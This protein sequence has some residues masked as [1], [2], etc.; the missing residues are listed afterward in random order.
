MTKRFYFFMLLVLSWLSAEA[1]NEP[2]AA[3]SNN[4]KTLTFYYDEYKTSRGGMDLGPFNK[5][6]DRGWN[7]QSLT[8]TTVVFDESFSDYT[9]LTSTAFWFCE[10]S[11]LTAITGIEHLNTANVTNMDHMFSGCEAL[12]SLDVTHFNTAKVTNMRLMFYGCSGLTSLDVS[13]FN[14]SNVTTMFGMFSGC[15]GLTSLDVSN[16]NTSNV[17]WMTA[18]FSSC[19]SLTS[20]DVT[21][22]NTD[23]V[24]EMSG[25]FSGCSGLKSLDVSNFNTANVQHMESMFRECLSLTTI[26]CNDAWN[27]K[28]SE[29]MFSKCTSLVGAIA[30]DESKTDVT[31]ANPETGYFTKLVVLPYA[32]LSEDNTTLTFYYDGYKKSRGG[33]SVGP[34]SNYA[35]PGWSGKRDVITKV[36]FDESFANCKTLTSTAR[37][38]YS[39]S[40][41]KTITGMEYLNTD[42]VTSMYEMFYGCKTLTSLDV[43]HFNTD[44]VTNMGF[45]FYGCSG[46]TSLDVS[47]FNTSNVMAFTAMFAYC[48]ALTSLDVS[49]FNT[50]NV[51]SMFSMFA[52]CNSLTSLDVSNFNTDKV[53]DMSYMFVVCP[54]LTVLD[55]SNFNTDNVTDMSYMFGGCSGLT[56][57]YCNDTWNCE[58]SKSMFYGCT[59]LVGAI[60][61]DESKNDVAYANTK[62]GY[63]SFIPYA[64]LS[65]DNK[66]LT[67]YCDEYKKSRGG[68]GVGP[69]S[70]YNE[71]GWDAQRANITKVVFDESF[72]NC[73]TLTSTAY[74]FYF[75][76][77]LKTITGIEHLNTDNVTKMNNMFRG[78]SNLTNLDV[79]HFNTANVENMASMFQKCSSLTS[80]DL[81]DFNTD[82]VTNMGAMFYG[83]S[84]LKTIYCNDTWS[85]GFSTLMFTD[86][87]SLVGAIAYDSDKKNV[88]YANPET[89]YFTK[90]DISPYA[91]LNDDNTT[92]TFYY[93]KYKIR[94][95][96]MDVGPFSEYG[97]AEWYNK[98]D[99]ITKVVFDE[100]FAKCKT[101]TSTAY[102]FCNCRELTTITGIEHLNTGNV[103]NMLYMF[104][105]CSKLTN[106]DV[107]HFNTANV[108]N[109]E[110]MFFGCSSLMKLDLWGF[111]TA[112]VTNMSGMFCG[113]GNLSTIYCNDAW[114][115]ESSE[116][117]FSGCTSLVGAIAYD[118]DKANVNYAN[119]VNGYFT[120]ILK[121]DVNDDGIV[122]DKDFAAVIRYILEG[123]Y[124]GFNFANAD[125]NGDRVINVA[126]IV[127]L[128]MK[129]KK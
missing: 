10:C 75:C 129:K 13:N 104:C 45:M 5:G 102:W 53:T 84:S 48:N 27:C 78:C 101:L 73:K 116:T 56:T 121:G 1:K 38:F 58:S 37:W 103:T 33:M 36:V 74:W 35:E 100:S 95:A 15:S 49:N 59:S 113:C 46:L 54:G 20:L 24:G 4:N 66:T 32:A 82:K 55:V 69:F 40:V 63:F 127:L 7:D 88:S 81:L 52:Y 90:V 106:L 64:V 14:S 51:V 98:R 97:E 70:D 43:T 12:T 124:E 112:K 65:N 119:P 16:F 122:D 93:D 34:F 41:L 91:V 60:A 123:D 44:K 39:C 26:Y 21:N 87:T 111:N 118:S 68:M 117:M 80:L 128:N 31:C 96:G 79:T 30:Y 50:S 99:I 120:G 57:I 86:C 8:I 115:C 77:A 108:K 6:T 107:T 109:M 126:D 17:E 18:M 85:C 94:R 23:E 9:E 110:C 42:N 3:L 92:L 61:Y 114:S 22:F 19:S 2:Y 89:G 83:C 29:S 105:N 76:S 47:N 28:A 71:A 25:M 62:T 72:A 11:V 67:F 125:M